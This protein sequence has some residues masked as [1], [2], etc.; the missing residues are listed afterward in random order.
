MRLSDSCLTC[1]I[2]VGG[3]LVCAGGLE[4]ILDEIGSLILL[5]PSYNEDELDT[6]L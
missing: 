2:A 5:I 3:L 6:V 4:L 1:S